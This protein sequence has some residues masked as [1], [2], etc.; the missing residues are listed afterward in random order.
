MENKNLDHLFKE[1]E[2]HFDTE[3]PS[4]GHRKRFAERLDTQ[5]DA[6]PGNDSLDAL[7][8]A[9]P[10]KAFPREKLSWWKPL[11]IAASIALLCTLGLGIYASNDSIDEKVED[12]SPEVSRTEFYFAGLI[13]EQVKQIESQST[14]QTRQLIDD[15]MLQLEK[16][17][18]DHKHLEQ[19]LVNG[20]NSKLILNA[21]ITNFRTRIDL[22]QE[23]L[24]QIET[25]NNLNQ[26]DD[27]KT[28][29]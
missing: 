8:D 27:T 2:G 26:Y 14:P 22:L 11:S 29:I 20:G 6:I 24:D 7:P 13:E 10:N 12:I 21:M 18:Q 1:L 5:S 3:T 4:E 25:I 28:T 15:T 23:V 9:S 19:D 16:L 17:K